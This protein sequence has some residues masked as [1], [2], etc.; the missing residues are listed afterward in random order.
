MSISRGRSPSPGIS[1]GQCKTAYSTFQ[2]KPNSEM[3][4]DP[5][6]RTNQ[7]PLRNKK[8]KPEKLAKN[9]RCGTS[10]QKN[11]T[12]ET[13]KQKVAKVLTAEEK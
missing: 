7:I 2:T 8:S 6:Q 9:L 4:H 3:K 12:Q 5:L 11:V 13:P 1:T 10:S